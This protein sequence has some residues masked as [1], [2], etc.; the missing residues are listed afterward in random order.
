MSTTQ[1][2]QLDSAGS[3]FREYPRYARQQMLAS[4][5]QIQQIRA[6]ASLPKEAWIGIED[7]VFPAMDDVLTVVDDIRNLGLT[8]QTSIF[9]KAVEWHK[10]DYTAEARI[11]MEPDAATDEGNVEYDL[12][13]SPLPV[14]HADFSIGWRDGGEDGL[15]SQEDIEVLN[16]DASGRAVAEAAEKLVL[17]GWDPT[18]GGPEAKT[19]GYSMYGLTN[20]PNTHTGTLSNWTTTQEDIRDNLKSMFRDLKSDNFRPGNRGYLVY[21]G[22]DLEDELDKPDPE[23]SGDMLVRDRIENLPELRDIRV[24]EFLTSDAVLAFRPTPDVVD[25]AIGLEEQVVQWEDPF[26][27]YFKTIFAFTPRVKDTLR[28]QMGAAY[29]TGGTS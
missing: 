9:N 5:A 11:S 2:T 23:G 1:S 21:I 17:E 3:Q 6:N 14:I 26:R 19:D 7:A 10:Q 28:G 4:D 18:I 22:E 13:G 12:D 8:T 20:H 27:D 24:S 16:A 15:G 25:L 29:Y